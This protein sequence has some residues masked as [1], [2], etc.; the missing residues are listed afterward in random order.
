MG[1]EL[2]TVLGAGPGLG[3]YVPG[4]ILTT[5]LPRAEMLVIEH[6]LAPDKQE[7]VRRS[8][9]RFH[10]ELRFALMAQ[11][12]A[13]N[14][15]DQ[16]DPAAVDATLRRWRTEGRRRFAVFSGFWGPLIER[17]V[18]EQAS[19]RIQ[20]D[21]CHVDASDSPSWRLVG[22][23]LA[24]VRDVWFLRADEARLC[25]RL[26][27]SG[28]APLA[29]SQRNRRFLIHGGGWGVGTSEERTAFLADR[30]V[31][32]DVLCYE[33]NEVAAQPASARRFL[34]DPDWFPWT[35]KPGEGLF[36]PLGTAQPSGAIAFV[37]SAAF[38]AFFH[39][40]RRATAIISK[41]GA[42][43]L[44]DS[45]AAATPLILL[46]PCGEHERQNGLVWKQLGFAISFDDWVANGCRSEP[47][48]PLH[49]A[50]MAARL[51]VPSY[52]DHCCDQALEGSSP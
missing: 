2:I 1:P 42:G 24:G 25:Y 19:E 46:P 13:K 34:L 15:G 52:T 45:L 6:L 12:L 51:R 44:I 27:V 33:R 48:E 21:L 29:W 31:Q 50:L 14:I 5:Q 18:R 49:H 30:G 7:I 32:L 10:Q 9:Q 23:R 26:D 11:R 16:L 8:R 3:F 35:V 47:L 37:S 39:L 43:T 36:P 41:P 17:Y 4:A 40:T 38:P 22:E 20:V 28:E